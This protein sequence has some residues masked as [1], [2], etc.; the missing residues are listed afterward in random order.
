MKIKKKVV[1][2]LFISAVL[3][4]FIFVSKEPTEAIEYEMVV[5]VEESLSVNYYSSNRIDSNNYENVTF[6]ITNTGEEN[7]FYTIYFSEVDATEEYAFKINGD[8][9]V[10]SGELSNDYVTEKIQ[11]LPGEKQE[12]VLDVETIGKDVEFNSLINVK[13]EKVETFSFREDI[14]NNNAVNNIALT[15]PGVE[16]AQSNEGLIRRELDGDISYY[17]RG[18]VDN[19][20]VTF[21][22]MT[23]RIVS[24]NEDGTVKIVLDEITNSVQQ[25]YIGEHDFDQSNILEEL[26]NWYKLSISEYSS[27]VM[28][29]NYCNDN[30]IVDS[31]NN[32]FAAY[33]RVVNDH[34]AIN[35]CIGSSVESNIGL[36]T[37][38]EIMYAG[39]TYQNDNTDYYLYN[40]NI[41]TAYYTMSTAKMNY[42]EYYPFIVGVN[43]EIDDN[44]QGNL[45]RGMRP[46]ITLKKSVKSSGEGRIDNPY[47]LYTS[48]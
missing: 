23:W 48:N 35:S 42:D 10:F 46:V 43:G 7:V 20:Y 16:S 6:S 13:N 27:Y 21:A 12:Y 2:I 14:L 28:N 15:T 36:L 37:V 4:V 32:I 44:V 22:D 29:Y 34:M 45:N 40:S 47:T 31:K 24:I 9:I 18:A 30:S 41:T 26:N 17:F 5:S 38:D 19:N 11:I 8:A 1:Y 3:T 39:G 25:Y 33:N